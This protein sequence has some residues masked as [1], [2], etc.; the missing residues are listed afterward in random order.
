MLTMCLSNVSPILS[1]FVCVSVIGSVLLL[2]SDSIVK[3][4]IVVPIINENMIEL[5]KLFSITML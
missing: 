1:A 4:S 2:F 5:D 3:Y